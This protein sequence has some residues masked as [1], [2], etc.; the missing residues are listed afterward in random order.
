MQ[1]E[2]M[3]SRTLLFIFIIPDAH[4]S[5]SWPCRDAGGRAT[6][7]S[8]RNL[9]EEEK[10]EWRGGDAPVREVTWGQWKHHRRGQAALAPAFAKL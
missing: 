6:L 2:R 4:S 9:E 1:L 3:E 8:H 5:I 10:R 7:Y